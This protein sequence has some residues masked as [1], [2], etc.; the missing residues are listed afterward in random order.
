MSTHRAQSA[1]CAFIGLRLGSSKPPVIFL[2]SP[3]RR[4]LRHRV[5][6][7]CGFLPDGRRG[8]NHLPPTLANESA[9]DSNQNPKIP[10]GMREDARPRAIP[11]LSNKSKSAARR[12]HVNEIPGRSLQ[13]K[14]K[15]GPEQAMVDPRHRA[16]CG[17]LAWQ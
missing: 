11:M 16:A 4:T 2:G 9:S 5:C 6:A 17:F 13:K 14:M 3:R 8:K 1:G 7:V 10:Y 15:S 12:H